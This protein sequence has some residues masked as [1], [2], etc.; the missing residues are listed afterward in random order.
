MALGVDVEDEVRKTAD[1]PC[2][3]LRDVDVVREVERTAMR[4]TTDVDHGSLDGVDESTGEVVSCLGETVIN[5]G[6]DVL[7]GEAA[8]PDWFGHRFSR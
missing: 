1:R 5:G 7:D 8:P 3:K 4:V 2:P 6:V